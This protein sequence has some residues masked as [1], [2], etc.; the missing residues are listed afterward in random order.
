MENTSR[1]GSVVVVYTA[2]GQIQFDGVAMA[3]DERVSGAF[4]RAGFAT[5]S[6]RRGR[7]DDSPAGCVLP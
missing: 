6:R 5:S 2:A 3:F 4:S 1:C 7:R